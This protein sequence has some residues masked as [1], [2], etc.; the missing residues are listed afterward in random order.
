[1]KKIIFLMLI[2]VLYVQ[3]CEGGKLYT[4]DLILSRISFNT[5]NI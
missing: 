4:V 5:I 1:M 3:F 2:Y